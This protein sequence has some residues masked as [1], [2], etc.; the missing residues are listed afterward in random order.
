MLASPLHL[1]LQ[2]RS[3]LQSERLLWC[4]LHMGRRRLAGVLW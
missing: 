4:V 1:L 2:H 3:S